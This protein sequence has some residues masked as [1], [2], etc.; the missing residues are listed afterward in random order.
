MRRF[1]GKAGTRPHPDAGMRW[2]QEAAATADIVIDMEILQ[3]V[4][5]AT[6]TG[7]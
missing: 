6:I 5:W 4:R 1:T 7:G 2:S 3:L